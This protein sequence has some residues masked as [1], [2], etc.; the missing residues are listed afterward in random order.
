MSTSKEPIPDRTISTWQQ[1]LQHPEKLWAHRL[2]FR[3]HLWLGMLASFYI[4]VM[5]IS[6]SLIVFRNELEG[7][8]N[9]HLKLVRVVEWLVDLH[10]NLRLGTMGR[11]VNGVGGICFTL[12]CLI[13][14]ILWWPGIA[15]WRRSLGVNWKASFARLNWDFH[16]ALGFWCFLFVLLWG[17]SGIYFAFPQPFNWLADFLQ[18]SGTSNK[19]EFGQLILLWLANLHFGR[20]GWFVEAF[21]AALGLVPA[22]LAFT[23]MFMCCHRLFVRKGVSLRR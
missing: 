9:Q 11:N 6:G 2:L 5:S 21:W 12:L 18:P 8:G 1:W 20:F 17:I 16:N 4:V 23:G 10:D 3:A 19:V 7:S 14:A 15:H 22:I 13:G